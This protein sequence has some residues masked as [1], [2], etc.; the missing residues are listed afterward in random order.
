VPDPDLLV[1]EDN[2][3]ESL[4]A[5]ASTLSPDLC[6]RMEATAGVYCGCDN[7]VASEGYCRICGGDTLLPDTSII[8]EPVEEE[9][10]GS[11]EANFDGLGCEELQEK[12][13][14]ECC[15]GITKETDAPVECSAFL[16]RSLN[17]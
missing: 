17:R 12:Y 1:E 15:P 6:V 16:E 13:F 5:L 8:G 9:S 4:N 10:C 7:P 11:L 14:D 2:T 3:C